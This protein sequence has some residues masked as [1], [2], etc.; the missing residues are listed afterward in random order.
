M[1]MLINT[2]GS[3]VERVS[4]TSADCCVDISVD[5]SVCS[6]HH[7]NKSFRVFPQDSDYSIK[8]A[9]S[10]VFGQSA[11]TS[12]SGIGK[13]HVVSVTPHSVSGIGKYHVKMFL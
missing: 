13:Y 9:S 1:V 4:L 11:L 12:V 10:N 3:A 7:C 5:I 6:T 8:I 2:T